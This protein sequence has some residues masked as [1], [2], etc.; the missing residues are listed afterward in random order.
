MKYILLLVFFIASLGVN[1]QRNV[2]DSSISTPLVGIHYNAMWPGGDLA[3]RYGF[4]N[5]IGISV[6]HKTATNWYYGLDA[7]FMFGEK[8]NVENMFAHLQD[9]FGRVTDVNGDPGIILTYPRGLNVNVSGGRLFNVFAP[10]KNSGILIHAGLGFLMH[11]I[12]I[13]TNDQVVPVV[14]LDYRKGYDRLTSGM[15]F[16]QFV[17]YSFLANGGAWNFYGGMYA[18][19]G[20]TKNRR[21]IFFDQPQIT[22]PTNI[23]LDWQV[24]LRVGWYIPFYKRL[25]KEFYYN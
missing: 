25:P 2:K 12:R 14:E 8:L 20:L 22:V 18:Q 10:N 24:G 5:H 19:Q 11:R 15:N 6:G 13:E 3:E 21:E 7:N 9:E 23:R 4:W 16:H 17:G 1:S